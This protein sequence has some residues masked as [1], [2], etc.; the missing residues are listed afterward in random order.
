[1]VEDGTYG[2]EIDIAIVGLTSFG[3]RRFATYFGGSQDETAYG[4]EIEAG[5]DFLGNRG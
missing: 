5:G 2:G 1:M 3:D 4:V